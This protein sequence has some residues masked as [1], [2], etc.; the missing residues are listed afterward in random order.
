[1]RG[2]PIA[3]VGLLAVGLAL[4]AAAQEEAFG[5][6]PPGD[7]REVV[8]YTC[9]ACHSTRIILQQGMSRTRW[10]HTLDWMREKQGM[11]AL[12]AEDREI[13]LDYLATHLPEDR[14]RPGPGAPPPTGMGFT[15]L[16]LPGQ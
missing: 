12:P 2:A 16:P 4:P 14:G 8:Y 7:G 9:T 10:D 15:P 13:I 11:P 5:G 6:L 3:G 1:M